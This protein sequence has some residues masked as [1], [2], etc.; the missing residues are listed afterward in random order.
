MGANESAAPYPFGT[1]WKAI[2]DR[3]GPEWMAYCE[4]RDFLKR[5]ARQ[6]LHTCRRSAWDHLQAELAAVPLGR[7]EQVAALVEV[8]GRGEMDDIRRAVA[9]ALIAGAP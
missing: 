6:A 2:V 3:D 7:R 4:A 8:V 5:Y 1:G 9:T